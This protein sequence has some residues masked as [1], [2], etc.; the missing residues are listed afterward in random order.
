MYQIIMR[1][2]QESGCQMP[3]S[4]KE[5]TASASGRASGWFDVC[6]CR[7]RLMIQLSLEAHVHCWP[8]PTLRR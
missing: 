6:R 8:L 4:V 5:L 7:Q 3:G 2:G 1:D